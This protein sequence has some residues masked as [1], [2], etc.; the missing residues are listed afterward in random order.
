MT[1][2]TT[3]IASVA[4]RPPETREKGAEVAEATR[5]PRKLP[6]SGPATP[7]TCSTEETRPR[8]ASG[9]SNWTSALRVITDEETESVLERLTDA[10]AEAFS[11]GA[12]G[13]AA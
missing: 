12:A 10:I 7:M 11:Y 9:V 1:T 6:S 13:R 3:A 2:A 8:Y 4:V 5:P